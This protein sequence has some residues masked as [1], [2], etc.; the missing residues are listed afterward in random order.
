MNTEILESAIRARDNQIDDCLSVI[1]EKNARIAELEGALRIAARYL[2]HPEV[3]AIPFDLPAE[4][5]AE[6]IQNL[7][8]G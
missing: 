2:E 6:Y 4:S 7:L 3:K 1:R 8:K 5:V